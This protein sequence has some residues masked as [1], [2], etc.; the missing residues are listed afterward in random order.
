MREIILSDSLQKRCER[1]LRRTKLF[2]V[3]E[4]HINIFNFNSNTEK[5]IFGIDRFKFH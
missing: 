5:F 3:I 1:N 2:Y 4:M